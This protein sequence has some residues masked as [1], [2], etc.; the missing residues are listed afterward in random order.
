MKTRFTVL[1]CLVVVAAAVAS[2]NVNL[3]QAV[4]IV[5]KSLL[6][7]GKDAAILKVWGP[8][9]EGTEIR[10]GQELVMVAPADGYVIYIDD[11]PTA[12]LFH[13]VRYAFVACQKGEVTVV[14]SDRPPLNYSDYQT[15]RTAIGEIL[16]SVQNRRAPLPMNPPP[17]TRSN[18]WAVLMSGGYAQYSNYP[19]YWN[20]LS[21]IY[22]TLAWTY[23]FADDHIIVLCSDGT[24]PS[25]DQS[26]GQNSNPDLD[27]DGDGDIMYPCVLSMVDAVFDSLAGL[28]TADDLL[29]IFTT[30]HGSSNG[31]WNAVQNLWN[32]EELTDAHFASLLDAL[33]PCQIVCTLE[34]CYSGGF[35]D[36][37]V[38]PPGP[39]V[40]SSAC[41]YDQL[42]WAMPPDYVYD[43]YVFHWTAAVKGEDAYGVA[44]DADYNGDGVVTMDEAYLYAETHDQSSEDPQYNDEPRGIGAQISLW[45][46]GPPPSM[47]ITLTPYGTPIQIPAGGGNFSYNVE[48]INNEATAV[49]FNVWVD[50]TLPSGT[51]YGP[52]VGPV[53][54][55]LTGGGSLARDRNQSVP[56][57]APAGVYSYNAYVGMSSSMV[58]DQ[59]SFTFEKLPAGD[60]SGVGN[61]ENTGQ[62]FSGLL[63]N[64]NVLNP[65]RTYDLR[66]NYPNPFNPATTITYSLQKTTKVRLSVYDVSGCLVAT[67]VDG[68]REAGTHEVV[69]DASGVAS[70]IYVYRLA[71]EDFQGSGK[72]VLMK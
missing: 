35:L 6:P 23:G 38:V 46:A 2:P 21:N 56:A 8:V 45:P 44:A 4:Q 13:P 39:R 67:L 36:N 37:V 19:R 33:P 25:P 52:V 57:N 41:R 18:R 47:T 64:G 20:D 17:P 24:N 59:D 10:A 51:N 53:N 70:G 63:G 66:A 61:W 9:G 54:L 28:L 12:N 30:D 65:G 43:T 16:D 42:S 58:Y 40:A 15:I 27:G 34:P 68:W 69:F 62:S 3:D 55:D 49:N 60:G 7:N 31:G 26:N 71:S 14:N 5:E 22:I 29:F 48:V 72:M 32:L 50:V 1:V 11:Y